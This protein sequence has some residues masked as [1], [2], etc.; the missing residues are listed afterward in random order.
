MAHQKYFMAHQYM[1]K[2][3][4]GLI[5]NTLGPHPTYLMYV[6]LMLSTPGGKH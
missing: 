3:F 4:H 2:I 1:L 5:K 6:P